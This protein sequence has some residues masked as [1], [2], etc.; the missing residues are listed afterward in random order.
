[1][2]MA[3][4]Q[5]KPD[6][7][8]K[9]RAAVKKARKELPA[10]LKKRVAAE[11]GV[12]PEKLD[13][14]YLHELPAEIAFERAMIRKAVSEALF[15][16]D[17]L[18]LSEEERADIENMQINRYYR[19]QI[20]Q[21]GIRGHIEAVHGTAPGKKI[22]DYCI[23][24]KLSSHEEGT[25]G[26]TE[27]T[28]NHLIAT[29]PRVFTDINHL[30]NNV[31]TSLRS[32]GVLFSREYNINAVKA[33]RDLTKRVLKQHHNLD[34]KGKAI[35]PYLAIYIHGKS[36]ARGSDFEIGAKQRDG[37]G[38][39]DPL[40]AFWI[41]DKLREKT[42]QKNI[43]NKNGDR[44]SVNVVAYG[45]S[46]S[47][48]PALTRM[49][50]GDN[51][52]GFKGLGENFHALQLE[53]GRF[54]RDHHASALSEVL[55]EVLEDFN[56]EF[57]QPADLSKLQP[58]E[59]TFKQKKEKEKT[60]LFGMKKILFTESQP[61]DRIGLASTQRDE[62]DVNVDDY[63]MV[64]G[65]LMS[66]GQLAVAEIRSGKEIKLHSEHKNLS[67]PLKIRKATAQEIAK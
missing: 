51:V 19:Y 38:P 62:L 17:I 42:A 8:A 18:E 57:K 48:S 11:T 43:K 27:R 58:Y 15:E 6:R 4:N 32:E 49:R 21:P 28:Q 5:P 60:E 2:A 22:I 14:Q 34:E 1:M 30:P 13:Q 7:I 56:N 20:Q 37:K 10:D 23:E 45:G 29:K 65:K 31:P 54:I 63:V 12:K 24:H 41:A 67:D 52:L 9:I 53:C 16:Q 66:V 46:Y 26:I 39:I 61:K 35:N 25:N 50:Y 44:P 64:E 33:Q 40:L 36:D 3:L 47:G 59:E 55:D